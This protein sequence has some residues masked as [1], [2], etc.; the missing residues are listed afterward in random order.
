MWR[1]E[2]F[3]GHG[4]VMSLIS[5]VGHYFHR[6]LWNWKCSQTEVSSKEYQYTKQHRWASDLVKCFIWLMQGH[7][8]RSL[9]D[10]TAVSAWVYCSSNSAINAETH[11]THILFPHRWSY[12][13]GDQLQ[14]SPVTG[15]VLEPHANRIKDR[16][17]L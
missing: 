13:T 4:V 3:S 7:W 17:R 5:S 11:W 2:C 6:A 9:L 10:W 14:I 16:K 15:A 12:S 8:L 1:C